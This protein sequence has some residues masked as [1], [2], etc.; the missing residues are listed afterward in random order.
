M[1]KITVGS[2]M[3]M[4]YK[5][6]NSAFEDIDRKE[7]MCIVSQLTKVEL[8]NALDALKQ[9][10]VDEI[11]ILELELS[12]KITNLRRKG[13]DVSLTYGTKDLPLFEQI[14]IA[15]KERSLFDKLEDQ[16]LKLIAVLFDLEML[17]VKTKTTF[18]SSINSKEVDEWINS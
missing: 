14:S 17:G 11:G 15:K 7:V 16:K 9:K 18:S 1:K 2:L 6:K 3:D 10:E 4:G 13:I 8:E 5:E 12:E